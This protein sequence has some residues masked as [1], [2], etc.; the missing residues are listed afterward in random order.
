[1]PQ[2]DIRIS[3]QFCKFCIR[4]IKNEANNIH[5][6]EARQRKREKFLDELTNAEII[7]LAT[8]DKYFADEHIFNVLDKEIV[9]VGNE[10]AA[11]ISKLP[12]YKRDVLLLSFFAGMT[13]KEIGKELGAIQQ[14]ISKRRLSS[15]LQLR[16]ILDEEGFEWH[17]N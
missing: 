15:L 1:M 8:N 6:E 5:T 7:S 10:L 13:D 3:K 9:V 2:N 17:D 4:V 12:Q 16:K 14:T 11:A